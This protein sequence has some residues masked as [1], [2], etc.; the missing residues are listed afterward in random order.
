MGALTRNRAGQKAPVRIS[1]DLDV[2]EGYANC[3]VEAPSTFDLDDVTGQARLLVV[4]V[5]A[6]LRDEVTAAVRACPV[7][8]I[9]ESD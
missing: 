3:V 8:A 4:E 5:P 7:R 6:D 1:V 9:S 2:C